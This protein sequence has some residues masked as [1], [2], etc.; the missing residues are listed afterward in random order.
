MNFHFFY[1][2]KKASEFSDFK[3]YHVGCIAVY[4]GYILSVGY[5]SNKTHPIQKIYN[6]ERFSADNTPHSLHAEIAALCLIKNRNDI[7]WTSVDLYIYRENKKG[8]PRMAKPC[9]SC[10]AMIKDLGIVNVYYTKDS[11]YAYYN[12]ITD[13][14]EVLDV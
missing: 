1:K 7:D 6:K 14:E 13:K 9:A 2:A 4:K 12:T 3:R 8:E 11:G 5:N 10:I